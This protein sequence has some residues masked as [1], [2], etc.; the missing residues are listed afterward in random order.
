MDGGKWRDISGIVCDKRMSIMLKAA[1]YKTNVWKWDV[2]PE[3]CW[4]K[5]VTKNINENVGYGLWECRGLLIS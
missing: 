2:C 1:V 3:K 5:L 4:A